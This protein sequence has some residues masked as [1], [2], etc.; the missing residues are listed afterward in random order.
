MHTSLYTRFTHWMQNIPWYAYVL[1]IFSVVL[2]Y[3]VLRRRFYAST[4]TLSFL[5]ARGASRH[6]DLNVSTQLNTP[7]EWKDLRCA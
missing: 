1:G 3:A 6:G 5:Q 4:H 2:I 7:T